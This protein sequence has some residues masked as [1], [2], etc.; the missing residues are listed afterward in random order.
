MTLTLPVTGLRV[1]RVRP[2]PVAW[3]QLEMDVPEPTDNLAQMDCPKRPFLVHTL[4]PDPLRTRLQNDKCFQVQ[5]LAAIELVLDPTT[6]GHSPISRWALDQILRDW[7]GMVGHAGHTE[8]PTEA[9]WALQY[10]AGSE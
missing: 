7:H 6:F 3:E 1:L 2:A 4:M 10:M 9:L 8:L 5:V